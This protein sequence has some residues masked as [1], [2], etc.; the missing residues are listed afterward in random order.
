MFAFPKIE[1]DALPSW[2]FAGTALQRRFRD[3]LPILFRPL[4]QA[5]QQTPPMRR[6]F[7]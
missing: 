6:E 2:P 5:S 3:H 1:F 4:L 7:P